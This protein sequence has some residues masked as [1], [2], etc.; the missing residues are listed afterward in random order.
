MF[1]AGLVI[2]LRIPGVLP[3]A[4]LLV[5]F[6]LSLLVYLAIGWRDV[7]VDRARLKGRSKP[8]SS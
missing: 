4:F 6:L 1:A 7:L 8:D 3:R 5:C 2:I